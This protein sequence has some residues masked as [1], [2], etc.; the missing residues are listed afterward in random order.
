MT[1]IIKNT[2]DLKKAEL[3]KILDIIIPYGPS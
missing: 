2:L 3:I 1:N